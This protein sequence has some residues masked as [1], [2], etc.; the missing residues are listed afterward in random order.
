[1]RKIVNPRKVLKYEETHKIEKR[2]ERKEKSTSIHIRVTLPCGTQEDS[3]RGKFWGE[4][5]K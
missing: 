3:R 2:K 4:N 5:V 1:L